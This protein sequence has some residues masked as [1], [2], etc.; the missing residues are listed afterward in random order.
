MFTLN[1][2]NELLY[3]NI[4][5]SFIEQSVFDIE[6]KKVHIDKYEFND[7]KVIDEEALLFYNSQYG[8]LAAKS[9]YWSAIELY[10][11]KENSIILSRMQKDSTAFITPLSLL[12]PPPL[13][14]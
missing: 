10:Q 7:E 13:P 8:L 5:C 14:K 1:S 4:P 2:N 3:N 11:S 6:G 12:P 9:L